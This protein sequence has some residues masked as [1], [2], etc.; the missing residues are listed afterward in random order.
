MKLALL[1]INICYMAQ[2]RKKTS[3][4]ANVVFVNIQITKP[5]RK[6]ENEIKVKL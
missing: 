4:T 5:E 2:K 1:C 3:N 6:E